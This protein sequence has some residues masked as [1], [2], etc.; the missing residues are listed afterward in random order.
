[1]QA[2]FQ[3][4]AQGDGFLDQLAE[5]LRDANQEPSASSHAD[6]LV[7]E[8]WKWRD[9][10][11]ALIGRASEHWSVDRMPPVDRSILR[12]AV[13]EMMQPGGPPAAVAID[14]AI[15]LGK[16]FGGLD[17]TQ[18][19]NGVLDAVRKQLSDP[20]PRIKR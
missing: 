19:I 15:E 16:Q 13:C 17:S 10:I 14:E 12:L 2:L 20:D 8:A 5:F 6:F 9:D 18:F 4:D 11:D 7:R 1:M 3:L